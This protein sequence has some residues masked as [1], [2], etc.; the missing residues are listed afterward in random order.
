M[1]LRSNRPSRP[2]SA[3]SATTTLEPVLLTR[4]HHRGEEVIE[5][6]LVIRRFPNRVLV[7]AIELLSPSKKQAPGNRLYDEKRLDL[8][9][10]EIHLVELDLL[11]GGERLPME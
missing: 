10:Q 4:P 11:I 6:R 1:I 3:P 7:T 5:K 8:I 2:E 9:H